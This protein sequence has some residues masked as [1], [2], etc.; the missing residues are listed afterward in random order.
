MK[1]FKKVVF[2]NY[3]NF[4][5]RARRAEYWW[6]TLISTILAAVLMVILLVL[7]GATAETTETVNTA[8]QTAVEV[9]SASPLV[10]IPAI[11]LGILSLALIIPGLAVTVRRLHDQDKS[12][13]FYFVSFI[14][15]IGGL[16]LWV[17]MFIDGTPGPNRYG[18][19]PKFDNPGNGGPAQGIAPPGFGQGSTAHQTPGGPNFQDPGPGITR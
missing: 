10:I 7:F 13:W 15:F 12:G 17:F 2:E 19:S 3:A 6:F 18:P 11:L 14:P 9:D 1:W 5:G 4:S 16:V 8:G